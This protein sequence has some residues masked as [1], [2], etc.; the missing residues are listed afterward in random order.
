M[1]KWIEN[2][3]VGCPSDLGCM[4]SACPNRNVPHYDCDECGEE[5]APG[6]LYDYEGEMLCSKCL[7]DKFT[8]IADKE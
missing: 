6:E 2:E 5:L 4:G 3:C 8:T 1:S 7:L